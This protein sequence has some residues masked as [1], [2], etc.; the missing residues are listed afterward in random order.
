MIIS[1]SNNAVKCPI[2]FLGFK[3]RQQTN[4]G[5][6]SKNTIRRNVKNIVNMVIPSRIDSRAIGR[7]VNR[8]HSNKPALPLP[9]CW[10]S[11]AGLQHHDDFSILNRIESVPQQK[12][13][14]RRIVLLNA[15]PTRPRAA[16]V[17]SGGVANVAEHSAAATFV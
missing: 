8:K 4:N 6:N 10:V 3:I 7:T 12:R 15:V 2:G 17:A 5:S 14:H 9:G 13:C 16:A 1:F 11:I